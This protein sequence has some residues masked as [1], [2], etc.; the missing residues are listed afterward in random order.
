MAEKA[1]DQNEKIKVKVSEKNLQNHVQTLVSTPNFRNYRN[2]RSLNMAAD[3]IKS[4]FQNS[5]LSVSEQRFYVEGNEYRNVI[6]KV[7]ISNQKKV[8]VGAHYDVCGDQ[9]GADDNASGVAGLLEL[10]RT[11]KIMERELAYEIELVAYTLEEPPY[12]RTKHMG[13]YNHAKLLKKNNEKIRAMLCFEM[14][15][16]YSDK[17]KSQQFPLGFMKAFY[18]SIGNFIGGVSNFRSRRIVK[19]F[20]IAMKKYTSLP[21]ETLTGPALI[22]GVDFSDH[23][24]YWKF[25]Y[26][27][28][29]ITDTAFYRNPNYHSTSDTIDSLDFGK[30]ALV[31]E[32]VTNLILSGRL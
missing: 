22:P 23:K 2:I 8:V 29:M 16:Y 1:F 12:F 32:G 15:G 25:G 11:L 7:G 27:A 28:I 18:P 5:D 24:N 4:T 10:G 19:L 6:A 17:K 3:Y 21:C 20:K 31:V 30:M 14:L 13:S 9:P 26:K